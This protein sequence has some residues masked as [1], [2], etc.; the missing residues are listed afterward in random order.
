MTGMRM[1]HG[2]KYHLPIR[3]PNGTTLKKAASGLYRRGGIL[4]VFAQILSFL[5]ATS[6]EGNFS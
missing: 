4:A 1:L 6:E 3:K 2:G 5:L